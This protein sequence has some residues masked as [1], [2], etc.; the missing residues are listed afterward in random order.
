MKSKQICS[1][2]LCWTSWR[3][4]LWPL[5]RGAPIRTVQVDIESNGGEL[6]RVRF[7]R[8]GELMYRCGQVFSGSLHFWVW[9]LHLHVICIIVLHSYSC[10]SELP[11][12]VINS[13]FENQTELTEFIGIGFKVVPFCV[14]QRG[15]TLTETVPGGGRLPLASGAVTGAVT[16][17][18]SSG[19][20]RCSRVEAYV[21]NRP[22][23]LWE[24]G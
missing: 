12:L 1:D 8:F 13:I 19:L 17:P 24:K 4:E 15:K 14:C 16:G 21:Q 20:L 22:I 9:C 7:V 2:Q 3:F 10:Y 23:D 18:F 11:H 5:I 6:N